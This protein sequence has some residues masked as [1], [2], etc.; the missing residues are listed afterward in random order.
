MATIAAQKAVIAGTTITYVAAAGGGDSIAPDETGVFHVR[1][2]GGSPITVTV[3][4]PRVTDLNQAN[5]DLAITVAAGA[6]KAI[7]PFS[8]VL[9]DTATDSLVDI[10]YSGVTTVTVAYVTHE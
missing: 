8:T 4:D 9:G 3:V 1:N 5:P 7:G 10:T 6:E 2:G